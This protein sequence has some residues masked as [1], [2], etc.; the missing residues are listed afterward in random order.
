[1]LFRG[2]AEQLLGSKIKIKVIRFLLS[3]ETLTSERELAQLIGASNTAVSHIIRDFSDLNLIT[4]YRIGNVITWNINKKSYAYQ[5]LVYFLDYIVRFPDATE[6]LKKVIKDILGGSQKIKRIVIFG[7]V[8]E[9]R[10]QPSSDIDLFILVENERSKIDIKADLKL[11]DETCIN[12]FG[13]KLSPV[14]FLPEDIKDPKQRKLLDNISKG[15]VV[16]E[17]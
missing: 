14:I 8:A 1:M 10:E 6:Y 12:S 16:V 9:G 15:I 11:L 7:S 5:F 3:G 17:R 4:P 13:N 2:F